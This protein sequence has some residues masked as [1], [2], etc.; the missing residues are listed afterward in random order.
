MVVT[1]E[2]V[3]VEAGCSVN[4]ASR[5]LNNK[6]DVKKETRER[7]L[8]AAHKLGYIP[9]TLAKSLVTNTTDTIGVLVPNL[10]TSIYAVLVSELEKLAFARQHNLII[11]QHWHDPEKESQEIYALCRKRVDSILAVPSGIAAG[12]YLSLEN[13][14]VPCVTV[15]N[16]MEDQFIRYVGPN[17]EAL[18]ERGVERLFRAGCRRIAVVFAKGNEGMRPGYI[19]AC[20]KNELP[21]NESHMIEAVNDVSADMARITGF[22]KSGL[23]C[24]GMILFCDDLVPP[25][26]RVLDAY[27]FACPADI[28]L[29]SVGNTACGQYSFVSATTYDIDI[30]AVAAKAFEILVDQRDS[31]RAVESPL[32]LPARLVART[33]C[34]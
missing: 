22:F 30:P 5:A 16:Q 10:T 26:L 13:F 1:L 23:A 3:A 33:S 14:R 32:Y 11:G 17:H 19:R 4:T 9:N 7:V 20:E 21:V 31:E 24:D 12:P 6:P 2:E 28:K 27:G 34:P 15:L 29:I 8:A 18:A 25:I